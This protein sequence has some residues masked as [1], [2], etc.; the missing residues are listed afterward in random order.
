MPHFTEFAL[1]A[2]TAVQPSQVRSLPV[3]NVGDYGQ[4]LFVPFS[5]VGLSETEVTFST[6]TITRSTDNSNQPV[7]TFPFVFSDNDT[8]ILVHEGDN[9]TFSQTYSFSVD[10]TAEI[11]LL[12][13]NVAMALNVSAY[14][15]GNYNIG[16]LI[17]T[18][19]ERDDP[20]KLVYQN[21]F[22]SGAANQTGTGTSIHFFVAD[23]IDTIK[24]YRGQALDITLELDTD[25]GVGTSQA[26]MINTCPYLNTAQLKRFVISGFN[27]HIHADLSHADNVFMF[28]MNRVSQ[29]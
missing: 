10:M 2:A 24:V 28:N 16:N 5:D 20:Q 9:T 6:A 19:K 23:I 27:A 7:D 8:G 3:Y 11:Y 21:T 14:T 4:D 22:S 29:L 12:S 1:P 25:L 15:S 26:G 18:I 13:L 17:F